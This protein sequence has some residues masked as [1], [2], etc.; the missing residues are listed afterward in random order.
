MVYSCLC[1]FSLLLKTLGF[2]E[3]RPCEMTEE[4]GCVL[5]RRFRYNEVVPICAMEADKLN[6]G[7]AP[8]LL[9]LALFGCEWSDCLSWP[10]YGHKKSCG[11]CAVVAGTRLDVLEKRQFSCSVQDLNPRSSAIY[12]SNCTDHAAPYR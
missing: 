8:L 2:P 9:N 3:I 4:L 10:F 1:N 6:G 7:M 12:P 11:S 5:G